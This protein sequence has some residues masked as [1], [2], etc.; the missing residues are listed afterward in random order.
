[1]WGL[2]PFQQFPVILNALRN[3]S[4]DVAHFENTFAR[5]KATGDVFNSNFAVGGVYVAQTT[6]CESA[7]PTFSDGVQGIGRRCLRQ[8]RRE[9]PASQT[10]SRSYRWRRPRNCRPRRLSC[11]ISILILT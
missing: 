6:G 3:K 9:K 8:L 10:H 1:M 5:F 7:T 11:I 4:L 2:T